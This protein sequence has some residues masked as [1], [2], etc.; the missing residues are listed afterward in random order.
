MLERLVKT[1]KAHKIPIS[2]TYLFGSYANGKNA[3]YSDIEE[4]H[5]ACPQINCCRKLPRL[6]RK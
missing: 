5:L 2:E 4:A 6:L 1:L 3:E